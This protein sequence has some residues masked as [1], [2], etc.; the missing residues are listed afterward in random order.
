M[1][2]YTVGQYSARTVQ[3]S[4]VHAQYSTVHVVPH[5]LHSTVLC[6]FRDCNLF[7]DCNLID[8]DFALE[9]FLNDLTTGQSTTATDEGTAPTELLNLS[10]WNIVFCA[11][12]IGPGVSQQSNAISFFPRCLFLP[13]Q[14]SCGS[15]VHQNETC[16]HYSLLQSK[17]TTVDNDARS[18]YALPEVHRK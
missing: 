8:F 3:Y 6:L 2:T 4:T 11:F 15:S 5:W 14:L 10:S 16:L 7:K 1:L 18:P 13:N 17:P 9:V 12:T